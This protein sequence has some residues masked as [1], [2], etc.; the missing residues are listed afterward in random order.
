MTTV[1]RDYAVEMRAVMDA[2]TGSGPY[3]SRIVAAQI[4]EKLRATNPDLLHG[5][6]GAQAET[7]LWQAINDRDR[8]LRSHVRATVGRS[9][10]AKDAAA[11][12]DGDS[13]ALS[14][15]L[16]TPFSVADGYRKRLGDMEKADLQFAAEAY[17]ARAEQNAMT[18]AL[19]AAL[20]K[21]VRKGTVAA[22]FTDD[23]LDTIWC[24]I[25]GEPR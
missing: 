2:E 10:F 22:Y 11:H 5:W 8:S 4:V 23:Q 25:A 16:S 14:R 7:F 12:E 15:W 3:V 24:S 9:V 1:D 13:G 21:K 17:R 20:A 18:A 6:L 19:L